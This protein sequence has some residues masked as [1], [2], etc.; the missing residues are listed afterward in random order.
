MG[1][2]TADLSVS[3]AEFQRIIAALWDACQEIREEYEWCDMWIPYVRRITRLLPADGGRVQ[4]PQ[5]SLQRA[6][7][8]DD[9][10]AQYQAG[11]ARENAA[12]LALIRG[13]IL[14]FARDETITL[15]EAN[16]V[17]AAGGL[18]LCTPGETWD[19][20]IAME[21]DLPHGTGPEQVREMITAAL[22]PLSSNASIALDCSD[23]AAVPA[24]DLSELLP[25]EER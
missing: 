13:R 21:L 10:W 6:W 9:G 25:K 1:L 7:L 17:L 5:D 11:R 15:D 16:R 19:V 2:V 22:K 8:T 23:E 20:Q 24:A 4:F 12:E 3:D 14:Q 18:A